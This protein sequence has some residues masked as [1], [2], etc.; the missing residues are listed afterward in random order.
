[1]A[2][3][4]SCVPASVTV[5]ALLLAQM[6]VCVRD[7]HLGWGSQVKPSDRRIRSLHKTNETVLTV[8]TSSTTLLYACR[9]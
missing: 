4:G 2:L 3:P 1:M 5:S 8:Y 7:G 6:V 9:I